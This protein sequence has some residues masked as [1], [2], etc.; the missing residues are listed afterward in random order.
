MNLEQIDH[1][2]LSCKNPEA[3][4]DWYVQVLG[5]EHIYQNEWNGIPIFL[6]LGSTAVALFPESHSSRLQP[7]T[8]KGI[9]HFA[10][11]A[12][13]HSDFQAAQQELQAHGIHFIFQDHEISHSIYFNDPDGHRLEI[14]SYDTK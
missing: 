2:A 5:F 3:S 4:K 8:V 10:L 13:T 12:K 6:K 9:S 11:L 7:N 14:T 1:L